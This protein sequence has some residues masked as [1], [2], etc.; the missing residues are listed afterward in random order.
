MKTIIT[1][2]LLLTFSSL[3]LAQDKKNDVVYKYKDY[4][5]IDLGS[6]EVK[7]EIVAPGD[8][9]V[10]EREKKDFDK[11]L[12]EKNNFDLEIKREIENLR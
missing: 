4:D 11:R 10:V 3:T 7:G 2:I 5:V 6:L 1:T 12:L 8:L 9:T